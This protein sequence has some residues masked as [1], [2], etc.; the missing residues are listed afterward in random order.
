MVHRFCL[1]SIH[2]D[3]IVSLQCTRHHF[4]LTLLYTSHFRFFSTI[5]ICIIFFSEYRAK[6]GTRNCKSCTTLYAL[7]RSKILSFRTRMADSV[8]LFVLFPR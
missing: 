7:L 2:T 6:S 8:I 3:L 4:H 1:H 5:T